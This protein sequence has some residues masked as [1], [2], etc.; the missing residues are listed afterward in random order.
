MPPAA[1]GF[2]P[3]AVLFSPGAA[4]SGAVLGRLAV[5]VGALLALADL[6]E[7]DDL[8]HRPHSH[9]MVNKPLSALKYKEKKF[10]RQKCTVEHPVKNPGF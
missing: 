8:G 3:F 10:F 9:S 1:L 6:A 4:G 2:G 5:L 7:V